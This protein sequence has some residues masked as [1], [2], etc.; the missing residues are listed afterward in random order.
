MNQQK[1]IR[2]LIENVVV[3]SQSTDKINKYK[4]SGSR[5]KRGWLA[6]T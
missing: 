2:E 6:L 5:T 4:D 3:F 1:N